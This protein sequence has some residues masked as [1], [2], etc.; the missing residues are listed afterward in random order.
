MRQQLQQRP[1]ARN[2]QREI[3]KNRQ[4]LESRVILKRVAIDPLKARPAGQS[5]TKSS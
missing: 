2:T 3:L 1:K 4:V 5:L